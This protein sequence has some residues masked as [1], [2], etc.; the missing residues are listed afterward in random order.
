MM[1]TLLTLAGTPKRHPSFVRAGSFFCAVAVQGK[2]M[3]DNKP[4]P[5][6]PTQPAVAK[7]P[8]KRTIENQL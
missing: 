5:E 6:A 8:K 2:I 7:A 3:A 4:A 1:N